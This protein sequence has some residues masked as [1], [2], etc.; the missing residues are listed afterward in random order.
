MAGG[1]GEWEPW[2]KSKQGWGRKR[3][4]KFWPRIDCECGKEE[5]QEETLD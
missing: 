4:R 3:G 5:I 1:W 2:R